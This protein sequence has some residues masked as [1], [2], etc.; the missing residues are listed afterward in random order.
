[1]SDYLQAVRK[2]WAR[3]HDPA[4][5]AAY[6]AMQA[7]RFALVAAPA[8]GKRAARKALALAERAYCQAIHDV[9]IR[10]PIGGAS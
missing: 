8:A 10:R 4:T 2:V 5:R 7:A 9:P 1:M 6:E 3:E